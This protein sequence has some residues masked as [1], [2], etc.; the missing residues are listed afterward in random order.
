MNTYNDEDIYDGFPT[1]EDDDPDL[2]AFRHKTGYKYRTYDE[3]YEAEEKRVAEETSHEETISVNAYEFEAICRGLV[4]LNDSWNRNQEIVVP[5][6]GDNEPD[7]II[8]MYTLESKLGLKLINKFYDED[9]LK[10][11]KTKGFFDVYP[12]QFYTQEEL[13]AME[14][15]SKEFEISKNQVVEE[16]SD[17]EKLNKLIAENFYEI[18]GDINNGTENK[19]E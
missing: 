11:E 6:P 14:K 18:F 8:G 17:V 19:N 4:K 10:W 7:C 5:Y 13:D 12:I 1:E 2:R 15:S 16:E 9:Y 3:F